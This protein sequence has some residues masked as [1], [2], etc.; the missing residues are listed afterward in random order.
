[1]KSRQRKHRKL[2]LRHATPPKIGTSKQR[3]P[4]LDKTDLEARC[5]IMRGAPTAKSSS[6]LLTYSQSQSIYKQHLLWVVRRPSTNHPSREVRGKQQR[7][8]VKAGC[9]LELRDLVCK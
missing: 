5:R 7:D 4:S 1:M 2:D 3:R 6:L 9:C 8:F